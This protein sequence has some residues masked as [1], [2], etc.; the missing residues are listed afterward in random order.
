VEEF[1]R[2]EE[3]KTEGDNRMSVLEFVIVE[4]ILVAMIIFFYH[5]WVYYRALFLFGG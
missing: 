1:E 4:A 3:Q 5:E 2:R